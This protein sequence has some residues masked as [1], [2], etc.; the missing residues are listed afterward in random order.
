MNCNKF[1]Q[2][3]KTR[4]PEFRCDPVNTFSLFYKG[5]MVLRKANITTLC[6]VTQKSTHSGFEISTGGGARP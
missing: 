2:T 6:A 3:S 5:E 4:D 1:L